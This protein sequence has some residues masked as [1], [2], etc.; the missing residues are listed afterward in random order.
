MVWK[1]VHGVAPAYLS[2]LCIP[3]VATSGQEKLRSASSR[4]L[5]VPTVRASGLQRGSEVSP[6]VWTDHLEPSAACTT[7][8]RAVTEHLHSALKILLFSTAQHRWDA[9]RDSGSEYTLTDWLTDWLTYLL[10]YLLT[11]YHTHHYY[12]HHDDHH[13]I[14]IIVITIIIIIHHSSLA[15]SFGDRSVH[16]K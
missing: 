11:Y 9:S 4:T 14:L 12:H 1:C 8:T 6:S 16:S 13:A 7:S 5:L 15:Q 2:D 10:T 3:A